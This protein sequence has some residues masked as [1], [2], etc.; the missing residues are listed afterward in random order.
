VTETLG[1]SREEAAIGAPVRLLPEGVA[2]ADMPGLYK[3]ADAFVLP[4]RGEGWGR[5]HCEAMAMGLPGA[6]TYTHVMLTPV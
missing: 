3:T 5:P 1:L 2:S 4:S 6:H